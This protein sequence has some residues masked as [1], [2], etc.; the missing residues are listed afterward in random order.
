MPP[1]SRTRSHL[2]PK[3]PRNDHYRVGRVQRQIR[4]A[5]TALESPLTTSELLKRCYPRLTQYASWQRRQVR[6]AAARWAV[7]IGRSDRGSGTPI[8]WLPKDKIGDHEPE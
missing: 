6:E 1:P 5:F 3:P 8:M 4:R 7:R 2:R